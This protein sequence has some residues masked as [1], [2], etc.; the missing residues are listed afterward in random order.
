MMCVTLNRIHTV[1]QA[2]NRLK[3]T[4]NALSYCWIKKYTIGG[5]V[6]VTASSHNDQYCSHVAY[7]YFNKI[8][9]LAMVK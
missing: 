5:Q 6:M 1:W 8:F 3:Q 2:F 7:T 9:N 4:H